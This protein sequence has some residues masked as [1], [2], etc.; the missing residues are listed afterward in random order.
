MTM[1]KLKYTLATL[2]FF[3]LVFSIPFGIIWSLNTLFDAHI[4]YTYKTWAAALILS[5]IVYGSSA[6]GNI[7]K[8]KKQAQSWNYYQ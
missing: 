3:T 2:L 7:S 8:K 1:K 4:A 6:T 5:T